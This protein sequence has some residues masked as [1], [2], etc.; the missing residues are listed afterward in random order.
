MLVTKG[1]WLRFLSTSPFCFDLPSSFDLHTNYHPN[2]QICMD[3]M[4]MM[5]RKQSLFYLSRLVIHYIGIFGKIL[6]YLWDPLPTLW[7]K[8]PS[9]DQ[10]LLATQEFTPPPGQPECSRQTNGPSACRRLHATNRNQ[11][12]M[13]CNMFKIGQGIGCTEIGRGNYG[14]SRTK[15]S[16]L[17]ES[18]FEPEDWTVCANAEPKIFGPRY[19]TIF[20]KI[21]ASQFQVYVGQ[22]SL[23]AAVFSIDQL[24]NRL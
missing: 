5:S 18:A 15:P 23:N 11:T 9:I 3:M 12:T 19:R 20:P 8:F 6:D 2:R 17:T 24:V 10:L 7:E 1:F 13:L 21:Q 4:M 16:S 22:V 14:T